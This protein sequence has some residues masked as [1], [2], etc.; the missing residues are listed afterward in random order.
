MIQDHNY[1]IE[2][3]ESC[4]LVQQFLPSEHLKVFEVRCRKDDEMVHKFE[5][6]LK[7][8]GITSITFTLQEPD[9]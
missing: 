2:M 8:F 6:M 3:E 1:G 7:D 5:K 4:S 9:S